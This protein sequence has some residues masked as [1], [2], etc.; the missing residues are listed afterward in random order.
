[1]QSRLLDLLDLDTRLT[2]LDHQLRTLPELTD[3]ARLESAEADL[4]AEVVRTETAVSD[5]QREVARAEAAVQQVRDRAARDQARLDEGSGTSKSLQGLQH[6]LAS[7][8]RRQEVL[9]DE[10]LEVME[11]VEA[12]QAAADRA[13]REHA[14]HAE[15][16]AALRVQRDE[17]AARIGAEREQVAEGRPGIVADLSAELLALYDRVRAHSG[18]GAAPLVQRRCGGCRLDL[19]AVDLSRIR[20]APEDEVLRCEECGRILVRTEESG[21]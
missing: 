6:E 17:K 13:V 14:T 15:K 12:A 16:L 2:Q 5:L 9:E 3:I 1:M 4:K 20:N 7:L 8:A 18:T 11:R 21:L 10:Q 19:N